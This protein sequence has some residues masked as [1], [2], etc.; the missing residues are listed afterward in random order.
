LRRA[1]E[2]KKKVFWNEVGSALWK[3]KR[4]PKRIVS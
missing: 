1:I 3:L 2:E 4:L